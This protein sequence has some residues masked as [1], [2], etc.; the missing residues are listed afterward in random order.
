VWIYPHENQSATGSGSILDTHILAVL[1]SYK[2]NFK[3]AANLANVQPLVSD[4]E[5]GSDRIIIFTNAL[6]TNKVSIVY[7]PNVL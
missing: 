7:P 3:M 4:Q 1:P 6:P 2:L 5:E